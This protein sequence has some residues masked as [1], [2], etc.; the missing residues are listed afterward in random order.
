MQ[1]RISAWIRRNATA[2][3]IVVRDGSETLVELDAGPEAAENTWSAIEDAAT[4]AG[5]T[6]TFTVYLFNEAQSIIARMPV[7]AKPVQTDDEIARGGDL[8]S[9]IKLLLAHTHALT[10]IVVENS[11]QM[12]GDQRELV[13]LYQEQIKQTAEMLRASDSEKVEA[14]RLARE[15]MDTAEEAAKRANTPT[16]DR[17]EGLAAEIIEKVIEARVDPFLRTELPKLLANLGGI[18]TPGTGNGGHGA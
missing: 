16:R 13:K 17:F 5:K 9:T 2:H 11:R 14:T 7:R 12:L 10:S 8:N 6:S 1:D 4:A 18:P 15:A 3:H